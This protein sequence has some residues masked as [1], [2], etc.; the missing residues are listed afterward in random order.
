M[1]TNII[2]GIDPGIADTGYGVIAISGSKLTALAYGSIKTKKGVLHE[3]R[4]AQLYTEL[5][6]IITKYRPTRMG[7]EKL[8]FA[9]N[10]TTAMAVA[11]ARGVSLLCA[12]QAQLPVIEMTPVQVKMG[13]TSYGRATKAQMQQMIKAVLGLKEIPKPDDAAD[14]LAI[15][16][17]AANK[18]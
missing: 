1:T 16:I 5:M 15:A 11:Q 13:L 12:A 8:F 9:Q 4:L 6:A 18:Q 7:I 2:L 14:A 3:Q 17:C 10:T